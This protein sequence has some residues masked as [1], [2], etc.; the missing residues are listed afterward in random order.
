MKQYT[1]TG[2]KLTFETNIT[3]SI[4]IDWSKTNQKANLLMEAMLPVPKKDKSK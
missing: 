2:S 3:N 1:D 4:R